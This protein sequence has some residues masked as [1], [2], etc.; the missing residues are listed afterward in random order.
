MPVLVNAGDYVAG[1]VFRMQVTY[2]WFGNVPRDYTVKV[3]SKQS[4]T[5]RDE[6]GNKNMVH[7]DGTSPSGFTSSSYTA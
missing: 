4:L 5:V 2:D 3:Y 1:D 6:N 7:M